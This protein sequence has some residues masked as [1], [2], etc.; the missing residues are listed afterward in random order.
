MAGLPRLRTNHFGTMSRIMRYV[1]LGTT[2]IGSAMILAILM[3]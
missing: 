3:L 1:T 2:D